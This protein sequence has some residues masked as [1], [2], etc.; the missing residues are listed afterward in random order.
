MQYA[1]FSFRHWITA[2]EYAFSTYHPISSCLH[3]EKTP[4]TLSDIF[5]CA[6]CGSCCQ[7]ETTVS[8]DQDD[9]ERMIAELGLTRQEVEEKYWR[10][11]G[12]VVQMKIVDHHCIFITQDTGMER[13]LPAPPRPTQVYGTT[14]VLCVKNTV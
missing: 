5:T 14:G 12:K 7:G 8:L 10:V 1:G 4:A 9:Q 3:H 6:R 2:H 13:P 11:T